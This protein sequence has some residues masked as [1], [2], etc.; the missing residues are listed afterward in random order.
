[1]KSYRSMME[2]AQNVARN[3]LSFLQTLKLNR[4]AR[5]AKVDNLKEKGKTTHLYKFHAQHG[6]MITFAGFEMPIWYKGIIPEHLAVRNGVGIFDVTHMGRAMITGSDASSFLNYVTTN[7]VSTLEPL[8]AQYSIMCNEKGGIKDD[9]VI[10]RQEK[11]AFFAVYNAANREKNFNWLKKQAAKFSVDIEDV[12]NDIAMFAV[13]GPK[14]QETLQKIAQEDLGEIE[15]FKCSWME[16]AG[17]RAFISRTG[18]TGE[19][20]F[21]IFICNSSTLNPEKAVNAWKAILEAGKEFKIEPCGLGARD[22][23]RLE[24]GMCLYGNDINENTT[25]FEARIGFVVKQQKENFIGKKALLKQKA[26]GVKRKRVGLRVIE[27]GIPRSKYEVFKDGKKIGNITSGAFS[28]LLKRGIAM[29]YIKT[30]YAV[31]GEIASFKLRNRLVK[32]EIAKFPLYDS[33][34]YGYRRKQ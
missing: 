5:N 8:D 31:E 7:D 18:Y 2:N 11:N 21:E 30:E 15:R 16:I 9:F 25:P 13:Q 1:M 34:Q 4:L 12:S 23:L 19:D 33:N 22:T 26:E 14:A 29:A 24:A 10:S 28:P 32:A 3:S 27:V 6:K 20:G 17:C